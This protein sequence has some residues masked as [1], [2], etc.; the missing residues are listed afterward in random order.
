MIGNVVTGSVVD[1]VRNEVYAVSYRR[2][3]SSL[4][5]S[6]FVTQRRDKQRNVG[7]DTNLLRRSI[8]GA[9]L[10]HQGGTVPSEL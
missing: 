10:R 7:S 4:Q 3:E 9:F 2:P 6:A 1:S 8:E 5:C